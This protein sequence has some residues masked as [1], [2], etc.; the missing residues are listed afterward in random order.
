[1]DRSKQCVGNALDFQPDSR[2]ARL[3]ASLVATICRDSNSCRR[4]MLETSSLFLSGSNGR[5]C[6]CTERP[7]AG[8]EPF[9]LGVCMEGRGR[10]QGHFLRSG[11]G[12]Q[13]RDYVRKYVLQSIEAAVSM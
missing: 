9:V 6:T 5:C 4:K 2:S 13:V 7:P 10:A 11:L 8:R 3:A 1:M 12:R